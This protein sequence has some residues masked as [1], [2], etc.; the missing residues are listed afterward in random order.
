[1]AAES[2][3]PP[4]ASAERRLSLVA[5]FDSEAE[6]TE[7]LDRLTAL[8]IE[9][10]DATIVRVDNSPPGAVDTPARELLSPEKRSLVTGAIAGGAIVLFAGLTLYETGIFSLPMIGGAAA[11]AF[12][13]VLIGAVPGAIIGLALGKTVIRK[14]KGNRRHKTIESSDGFLVVVKVP[15]HLA[16]TAETISRRLGAREVLI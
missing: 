10:G 7:L 16:E 2:N 3:I 8:Q 14:N 1:M 11:H 12:A 15:Y 6:A 5:L 13:F 4:G 9:T